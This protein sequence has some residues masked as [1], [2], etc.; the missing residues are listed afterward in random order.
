[1]VAF[2]PVCHWYVVG[3]IVKAWRL[4]SVQGLRKAWNLPFLHVRDLS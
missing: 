4:L 2:S 3:E 1:M